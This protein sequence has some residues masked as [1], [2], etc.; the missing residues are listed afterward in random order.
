MEPLEWEVL[1]QA[2]F[3]AQLERLRLTGCG[4]GSTELAA[5]L[6]SA[7]PMLDWLAINDWAS[8]GDMGKCGKQKNGANKFTFTLDLKNWKGPKTPWGY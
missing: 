5:L 2:P 3:T 8:M 6:D 7:W 1:S 4:L